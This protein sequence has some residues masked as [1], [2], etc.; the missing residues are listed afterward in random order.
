MALDALGGAS[1]PSAQGS[2]NSTQ[3]SESL[4]HELA[5]LQHTFETKVDSLDKKLNEKMDLLMETISALKSAVGVSLSG[6]PS[7]LTRAP[8]PTGPEGRARRTQDG[9][10]ER[11]AGEELPKFQWTHSPVHPHLSG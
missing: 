3:Q 11:R 5:T 6:E 1:R 2:E 10:R 9:R 8:R 4:K 7:D